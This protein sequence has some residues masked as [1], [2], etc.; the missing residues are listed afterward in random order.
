MIQNGKAYNIIQI[1]GGADSESTGLLKS[2]DS[3]G[4]WEGTVYLVPFHTQ[5]AATAIEALNTPV[6][7]T[8]NQFTT[9]ELTTIKNSDQVEITFAAAKNSDARA[10]VEIATY[11][12]GCLVGDSTVTYE[13][14]DTLTPY[15]YVL[16]N[17][18]YGS[19]LEVKVIFHTESGDGSMDSIKV[20]SLRG[21]L[22]TETCAFSY[23][24][25][26]SAYRTNQPHQGGVTFDLL[27]REMLG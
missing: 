20:E 4:K 14:T 18:L 1:G 24:D 27:G 22:Q 21:T 13:L 5:M 8:Q 26:G 6:E 23:Y 9:G 15:R 12:K 25:G 17:Q 19:G 16:S 3:T 11:Y 2:I 7:G 10:W